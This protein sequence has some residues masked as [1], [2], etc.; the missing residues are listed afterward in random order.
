MLNGK[1][2]ISAEE[3]FAICTALKVDLDY[4]VKSAGE[5]DAVAG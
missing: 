3:Y 1:R 2:K 4:F 5:G